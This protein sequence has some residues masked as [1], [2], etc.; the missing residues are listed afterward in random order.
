MPASRRWNRFPAHQGQGPFEAV[1]RGRAWP[2]AAD[3]STQASSI[4]G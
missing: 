2:V 4:E 3:T 1:V